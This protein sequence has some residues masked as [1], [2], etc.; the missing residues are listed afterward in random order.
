MT[1]VPIQTTLRALPLPRGATVTSFD[2]PNAW[3]PTD[4]WDASAISPVEPVGCWLPAPWPDPPPTVDPESPT[5]PEDS[6]GPPADGAAWSTPPSDGPGPDGQPWLETIS[7]SDEGPSE[8]LITGLTLWDTCSA[9]DPESGSGVEP[10]LLGAWEPFWSIPAEPVDGA[11]EPDAEGSDPLTHQGTEIEGINPEAWIPG[12]VVCEP[13]PDPPLPEGFWE[14]TG[15]PAAD[16]GSGWPDN[17]PSAVSETTDDWGFVEQ[18]E[19]GG[20]VTTP[21]WICVLPPPRFWFKELPGP[22]ILNRYWP[23]PD[24]SDAPPPLWRHQPRTLP[25]DVSPRDWNDDVYGAYQAFLKE[26]PTWKEDNGAGGIQLQVITA[27]AHQPWIQLST[28]GAARAFDAW[29]ERHGM[30]WLGR[31]GGAGTPE[32]DDRRTADLDGGAGPGWLN[33]PTWTD[34]TGEPG[35]QDAPAPMPAAA[36]ASD[37]A[38]PDATVA[39]AA[40]SPAG[41]GATQAPDAAALDTPA[42]SILPRASTRPTPSASTATNAARSAA[43]ESGAGEPADLFDPDPTNSTATDPGPVA[44]ALAI[45]SDTGPDGTARPA[46]P[47]ATAWLLLRRQQHLIALPA[48]LLRPLRLTP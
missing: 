19:T 4:P 43:A 34:A 24:I 26:N 22:V 14:E 5:A 20:D 18:T 45:A 27:S 33:Q 30:A 6:P 44:E 10:W 2:E 8:D 28:P 15:L 48:W 13:C 31:D 1:G 3:L 29:Y 32:G 11:D 36:P 46:S 16:D 17:D 42:V 21:I 41:A 39:A 40:L 25:I 9:V 47:S 12:V 23:D 35:A 38:E 37:P 7:G